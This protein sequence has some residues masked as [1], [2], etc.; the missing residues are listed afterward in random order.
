MWLRTRSC[1]WA[2]RGEKDKDYEAA[3]KAYETAADRYH[4]QPVI[5]A[6]AMYRWAIAYQKQATKA[7]YDQGKAGQAIA[8]YT[9]FMTIFPDDKRAAD[10]QKAIVLLKAEQV[11]GSF[12]VA[13][14]Y[15]EQQDLEREPAAQRRDRLLQRSAA[16]Q[17]QLALRGAG[18]AAHRSVETAPAKPV[19]QLRCA[20]RE[21][22]WPARRPCSP[23]APATISARSTALSPAENP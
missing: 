1:R 3:V 13:Q 5:A 16:A 12:I 17:P 22:F 14:F 4:N 7:E 11:R 9:D 15:R 18:P 21:F 8:A 23:V 10:A 20:C 6:D 19:R 2:P